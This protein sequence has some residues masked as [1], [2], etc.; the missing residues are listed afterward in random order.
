M[1]NSDDSEAQMV[2][3]EEPLIIQLLPATLIV[4]TPRQTR[5]DVIAFHV[6]GRR[7]IHSTQGPLI[8]L[9]RK[10]SGMV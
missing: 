6:D 7:N 3:F 2:R 1:S 9:T 8:S 10:P 5:S 4:I